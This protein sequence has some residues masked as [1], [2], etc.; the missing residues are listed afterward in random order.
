MT[1]FAKILGMLL[2]TSLSIA[3]IPALPAK[4]CHEGTL[5]RVKIGMS[6]HQLFN[7]GISFLCGGSVVI[8]PYVGRQ[9]AGLSFCEPASRISAGRRVLLIDDKVVGIRKG[10]S[11][12][13]GC[14]WGSNYRG[15]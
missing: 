8:T 6:L 5:D 4:A 12:S 15:D 13:G 11:S 9:G 2:S 3:A 10:E 1:N 7:G 14:Y